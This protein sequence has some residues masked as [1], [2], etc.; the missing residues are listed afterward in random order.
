MLEA[1][2]WGFVGGAALLL[3]ALIGLKARS[4]QRTIGLVMGF[5]SGVLISALA[6]E[7]TAESFER[8]GTAALAAGLAAGGLCFFA[9]DLII[10][11]RG[12]EHRKRSGGEQSE[13]SPGAIVLGARASV[14]Q[15]FSSRSRKEPDVDSWGRRP[16][17]NS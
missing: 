10:D 6:F 3:G 12:G 1:G 4:S 9:G 15:I 5:G 8:G 7:L 17:S 2:F 16:A 13:G 11:R 14:R